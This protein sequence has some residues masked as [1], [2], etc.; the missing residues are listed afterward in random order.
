MSGTAS[1]ISLREGAWVS[2]H[3]WAYPLRVEVFV[4][5][6]GVPEALEQDEHDAHAYHV[7]LLDGDGEALATGRLL[8]DGHI[9]RLA[10]RRSARGQGLGAR[11]L[12]HLIT[13]ARRHGARHVVL[14]AQC[15]A[16]PFYGRHGFVARGPVFMD[17]GIE[18]REMVLS[19]H[20]D[21]SVIEPGS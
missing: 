1:P 17:A 15:H 21:S 8:P 4:L 7:V 14:S 12:N 16:I 9:G 13:C 18:H 2:L 6:Q 10:V 3:E 19:L 5:E 20:S 11:V